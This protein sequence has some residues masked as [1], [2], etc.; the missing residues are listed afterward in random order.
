MEILFYKLYAKGK[1]YAMKMKDKDVVY[2]YKYFLHEREFYLNYYAKCEMTN[3][4]ECIS[5]VKTHKKMVRVLK[6][7]IMRRNLQK[8]AI[9]KK[10]LEGYL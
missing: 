8:H 7:E 9:Y 5:E 10:M 3:S 4:M 1:D 6:Q 2:F